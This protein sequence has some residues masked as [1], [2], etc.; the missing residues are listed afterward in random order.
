MKDLLYIMLV[1]KSYLKLEIV[2]KSI[3]ISKW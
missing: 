1:F 3:V 2:E